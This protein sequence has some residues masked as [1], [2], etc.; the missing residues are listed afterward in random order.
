MVRFEQKFYRLPSNKETC[1]MGGLGHGVRSKYD[2]IFVRIQK[3][4]P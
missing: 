1:P 2:R 3:L 4:Y